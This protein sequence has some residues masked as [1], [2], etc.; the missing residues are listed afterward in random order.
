[1]ALVKFNRTND[2]PAFSRFFDDIFNDELDFFVPRS[3]KFVP[4]V[5]ITEEE[6]D[7]KIEVSAPGFDKKDFKVNLDKS[8]LT[9]EANIEESKEENKKNFTRKEFHTASFSRSFNLPDSIDGNKIDAKYK[10][11]ILNIL[12]PKKEEAVKPSRLISI[13]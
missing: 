12:L 13:S 4:A 6:K 9:I 2:Y 5:N 10:N 8:V 3:S 11:G 1:M 7:F